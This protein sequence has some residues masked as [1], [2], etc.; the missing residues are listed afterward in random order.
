M[1]LLKD[2]NLEAVECQQKDIFLAARIRN[3]GICGTFADRAGAMAYIAKLRAEQQTIARMERAPRIKRVERSRPEPGTAAQ[4]RDS[5]NRRHSFNWL[6][7]VLSPRPEMGAEQIA[8]GSEGVNPSKEN[9]L[10]ILGPTSCMS[11]RANTGP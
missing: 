3:A 9:K 5:V 6:R 8:F 7:P 1:V 2:G 4:R 10:P 11:R